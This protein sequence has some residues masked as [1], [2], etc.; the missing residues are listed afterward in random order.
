MGIRRVPEPIER[1]CRMAQQAKSKASRSSSG[2]RANTR[3][4]RTNSRTTTKSRSRTRPSSNGSESRATA[5]KTA[6][7]RRGA[8]SNSKGAIEAAKDTTVNGAKTAGNAV[9]SAA[10]QFKTPAI[11]AGV[12]LAGLAGGVALGRGTKFKK[13]RGPLRGRSAG[14]VTSKKLS[15]GVK[16]VGAVAEQTGQ[17]AE[18]V[19]LVSEAIGRDQSAPR[20]SPIE[21]VLEGLTRRSTSAAPRT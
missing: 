3:K 4:S 8:S 7:S 18:R 11:A 2:S 17:V 20:R 6:A 14:K 10:K 9:A 19:R 21:V 16:T 1:T 15:A 13:S 12:G 5:R